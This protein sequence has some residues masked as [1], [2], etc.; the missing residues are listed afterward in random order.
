MGGEKDAGNARV[1]ITVQFGN[2]Q[3]YQAT[4]QEWRMHLSQGV[5][6]AFCEEF[7]HSHCGFIHRVSDGSKGLSLHADLETSEMFDTLVANEAGWWHPSGCTNDHDEGGN[8]LDTGGS[9]IGWRE[10]L[11]LL[12]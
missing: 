11:P 10:E 4:T 6:D 7:G 5:R 2:G 8:C 9:I 1:K 12:L 3:T